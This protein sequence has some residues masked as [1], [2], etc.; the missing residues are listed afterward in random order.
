MALALDSVTTGNGNINGA[1][2]TYAHTC[3]GSQLVLYVFT[4]E[5]NSTAIS[6]VTYA[7]SSMTQIGQQAVTGSAVCT[8][9]RMTGPATGANNVVLASTASSVHHVV[10]VAFSFTGADQT[11]PEG[12]PVGSTANPGASPS[13]TVTSAAGEIVID[14]LA[15]AENTTATTA[16]VGAGQTQ[17]ANLTD[18][19][20]PGSSTVL[21]AAS[22]ETGAASVVMS[23]TLSTSQSYAHV[24]VNVKPA[25]AGGGGA[26]VPERTLI[27]AGT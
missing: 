13:D 22:H 25:A 10:S 6:G 18:G 23:W 5:R 16:T 7:G 14:G 15:S 4:M 19:T 17:D 11:T 27:G 24:A 3:T 20:V 26:T 1:N 2:L 12:T 21:G 9:W 8:L